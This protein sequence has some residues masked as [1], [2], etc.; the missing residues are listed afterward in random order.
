MGGVLGRRAYKLQ[1][2][3]TTLFFRG[4]GRKLCGRTSIE[5]A[6]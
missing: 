6:A 3:L 4:V 1:G 2:D 5:F